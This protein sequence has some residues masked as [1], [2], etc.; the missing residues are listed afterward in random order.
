MRL[1]GGLE[2]S[3][4]KTGALLCI[5]N[6][7]SRCRLARKWSVSREL[8]QV[9]E[10]KHLIQPGLFFSLLAQRTGHLAC[11]WGVMDASSKLKPVFLRSRAFPW[12][13]QVYSIHKTLRYHLN[14]KN[15][16][17][18]AVIKFNGGYVYIII[19]GLRLYFASPKYT[20]MEKV[21]AL[22]WC[23][24]YY[25]KKKLMATC[26]TSINYCRLSRFFVSFCMH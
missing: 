22:K 18:G 6:D 19:D 3:K 11:C 16:I 12:R 21:S 8:Y 1:I 14:N 5:F 13:R 17:S 23:W 26:Q 15:L 7:Y 24:V 4:Q 2:K 9:Q 20:K 25:S 10:K